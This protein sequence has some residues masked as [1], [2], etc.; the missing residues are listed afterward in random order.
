MEAMNALTIATL[1]DMPTRWRWTREFY[2]RAIGG[3][4]VGEGMVDR[5]APYNPEHGSTN[6]RVARAQ[7]TAFGAGYDIR[8]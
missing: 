3:E 1:L 2:Y 6:R 5:I 8:Y 7:E 4:I